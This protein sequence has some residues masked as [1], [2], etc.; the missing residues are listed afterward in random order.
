MTKAYL[1]HGSGAGPF[2]TEEAP[3]KDAPMPHHK[4]G[5]SWT[6]SGYGYRIPMPYMVQYEGRW[7]RVYVACYGNSGTAYIGKNLAEGIK[8]DIY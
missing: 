4:R 2:L 7:R 3:F 1:Q 5:L 8:V 6:A